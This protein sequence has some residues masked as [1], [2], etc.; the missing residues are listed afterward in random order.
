MHRHWFDIWQC[1]A[2]SPPIGFRW[3]FNGRVLDESVSHATLQWILWSDFQCLSISM[4][5]LNWIV[6]NLSKNAS[7]DGKY[8]FIYCCGPLFCLLM[9]DMCENYCCD[10][11]KNMNEMPP[12][13]LY[14]FNTARVSIRF[15]CRK[16]RHLFAYRFES[17]QKRFRTSSSICLNMEIPFWINIITWE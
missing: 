1:S 4:G 11:R 10:R 9:M 7:T 13:I 16:F 12:V 6:M 5:E 8:L 17:L 15:R 14:L 2:V 3:I